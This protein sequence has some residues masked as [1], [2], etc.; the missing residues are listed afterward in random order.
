MNSDQ[1][2]GLPASA[3]V[4]LQNVFGKCPQIESVW[5]YGSR[6]KGNYRDGSD[7]DLTIKGAGLGLTDL[8]TIE[9]QIDDLLLPWTVDLSLHQDID[10]DSLREHIER[11]GVRFYKRSGDVGV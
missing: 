10:N 2:F 11:V 3:I 6:A 7:I 1:Q 4:A 8:L 5:L 9:T